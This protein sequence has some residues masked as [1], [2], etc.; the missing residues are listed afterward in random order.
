[1][2]V[3]AINNLLGN[4]GNAIDFTRETLLKQGRDAQLHQAFG[5]MKDGKRQVLLFFITPILFTFCPEWR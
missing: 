3:N 2:L 4:Y 1:M 5:A